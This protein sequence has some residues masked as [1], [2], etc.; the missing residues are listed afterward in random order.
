MLAGIGER[1]D[2]I[3][4]PTSGGGVGMTIEERARVVTACRPEM[5]TFK[6]SP[7]R[8]T[9]VVWKLRTLPGESIDGSEPIVIV[10][11]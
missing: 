7:E 5:A 11:V 2:A 3:V 6:R 9:K 8:V 1:C 10:A 4:Q